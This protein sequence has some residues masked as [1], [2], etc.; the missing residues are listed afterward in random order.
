MFRALLFASALALAA[1]GPA[2]DPDP[3]PVPKAAAKKV[4]QEWARVGA[5]PVWYDPVAQRSEF[6]ANGGPKAGWEY[7]F[8]FR[9]P[10]GLGVAL[11]LLPEPG[12]PFGV[13]FGKPVPADYLTALARFKA[14]RALN[15]VG[16]DTVVAAAV[17]PQV[18][19]LR[20]QGNP[21]Y[22]DATKT[23][24]GSITE[25]GAKALAGMKALKR[26]E[27]GYGVEESA[28]AEC[29]KVP[30]LITF[31][32]HPD[33]LRGKALE[34]FAKDAKVERL[35]FVVPP[36]RGGGGSGIIWNLSGL[37]N[38]PPS[39]A[40]GLKAVAGIKSL[41]VLIV[42]GAALDGSSLAAL[43]GATQLT[44]LHLG[45][46]VAAAPQPFVGEPVPLDKP[47]RALAK[48]KNLKVLDLSLTALTNDG[49]KELEELTE[50][51]L[52]DVRKTNVTQKGVD[53]FKAA[54][55][56]CKVLWN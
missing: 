25:K 36:E 9:E 14:L 13:H 16:D 8:S 53:S 12:V 27:I 33:L 7:G 48:L 5:E 40:T 15:V 18:E 34:L 19:R 23:I 45:G 6:T 11:D 50:L 29:A 3:L 30:G 35:E 54:V 39:H 42:R 41:R 2:A 38:T 55:P 4:Q 24:S 20:L 32:C 56:K 10:K 46:C 51:T 31:A 28:F 17:L 47:I 49:L 1:N 21:K 52:L 43:A 44:E 37:G 22:D 26:L